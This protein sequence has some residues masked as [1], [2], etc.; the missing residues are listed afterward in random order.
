MS[1]SIHTST[2]HAILGVCHQAVKVSL[3][4]LHFGRGPLACPRRFFAIQEIKAVIS[5]LITKYNISTDKDIDLGP[6]PDPWTPSG[7]LR[8]EPRL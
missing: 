4:Y 2:T 1:A 5:M 6:H 7:T 3:D 8:F